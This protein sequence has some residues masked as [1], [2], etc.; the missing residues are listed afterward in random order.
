LDLPVSGHLEIVGDGSQPLFQYELLAENWS[1]IES[2]NEQ[3]AKSAIDKKLVYELF[4]RV[5]ETSFGTVQSN[6]AHTNFKMRGSTILFVL[7]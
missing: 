5:P 7:L 4:D 2:I 1:L 3:Q 6:P